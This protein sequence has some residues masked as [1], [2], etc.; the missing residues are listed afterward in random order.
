MSTLPAEAPQ[1]SLLKENLAAALKQ[2]IVDGRLIPG[3]R[4]VEGRWA[5]EFGVA[6]ASVRE[7]INLLIAE[8]FLIKD[9]GRSA[10][11]VIYQEKD[12][13][14]IYE[15]RA[16]MEGLAAQLACSNRA[17]LS[18]VEAAL[19]AMSAAVEKRAMKTLIQSDLEFHLGLMQAAGN[20]LLA[21]IGRKLLFPLFAFIQ[22]KVLS[23]RQGPEP[24]RADLQYHRLILQVLREGNPALSNE[25]VQHCIKRFAVSAYGV[26]ENVG[27]SVEAHHKGQPSKIRKGKS[28]DV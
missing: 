7:A 16:A 10:R 26:W 24:W 25:F 20:P 8:G 28:S 11:V 18:Q 15:V 1:A 5:K 13:A 17:D 23:S 6:Q 22:M 2:A 4:V 14:D 19:E 27:G 3:H 9:A 21:E 12:V